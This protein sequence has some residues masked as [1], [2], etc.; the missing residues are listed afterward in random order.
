MTTMPAIQNTR[1]WGKYLS[2]AAKVTSVAKPNPMIQSEGKINLPRKVIRD[3][4]VRGMW[5]P[6]IELAAISP[7]ELMCQKFPYPAVRIVGRVGIVFLPVAED[8][9]SGLKARSIERMVSTGVGDQLNRWS[10]VSPACNRPRAV[11]GRCPV[12]EFT[13]END[14][15]YARSGAGC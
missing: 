12:V 14:G 8:H 9:F 5:A 2:L 10:R 15:R 13:H 7:A 4:R 11:L 6:R 3:E 1:N